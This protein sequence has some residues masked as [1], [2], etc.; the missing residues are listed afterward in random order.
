MSDAATAPSSPLSE[1]LA[2][3]V[4][5]NDP[6]GKRPSI[7][8][9]WIE[10]EDRMLRLDCRKPKEAERLIRWTQSDDFWRGNVRSMPTFRR[11]YGQLYLAAVKDSKKRGSPGMANAHRLA[12]KARAA[13]AA[14]ARA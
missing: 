9:E 12:E 3:L 4:A 14:E 10:A 7:S 13:E 2:D 6:D 5:E 1:L 8:K 11:Q